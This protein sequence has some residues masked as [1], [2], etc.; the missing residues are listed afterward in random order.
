MALL[1]DL[2]RENIFFYNEEGGGEDDR[3]GAG[4]LRADVS[5]DICNVR[6]LLPLTNRNNFISLK[7]TGSSKGVLFLWDICKRL[8]VFFLFLTVGVRPEPASQRA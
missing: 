5:Q 7:V 4:G 6:Y 3:V 2:P 8:R 1:E